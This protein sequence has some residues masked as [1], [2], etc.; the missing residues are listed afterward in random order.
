LKKWSLGLALALLAPGAV[1]Q[2][3][4]P[5]GG[6]ALELVAD[7]L[8][9]PVHL[10]A[11]PN[12][13]RLFIVEQTG[14]ILIV[15]D[16]Q[17]RATPFLDIRSK[18]RS[19]GERG[20]LSVAFHPN[21]A[22][23]GFF[24]VNYTDTQGNTQIERYRVGSDPDVAD[25]DSAKRILSIAQPQGNHNGGLS[26]FGPDGMLWIGTGDGGG[27]ND[28]QGNG[29]RRTT[30]LGK[31][32]RIDVDGG[33]PYAIPADNP[34]VN[35][36]DILPEIWALGLRNPW[37]F[38]FDRATGLL[39]IAD[40]GQNRIEEMNA[41]P[42]ARGG[43]NFGWNIMEG[44]EC[45]RTPDCQQTG[46]TLPVAE[47]DHSQ[48]CSVTGGY[49]YRGSRIPSAVGHYFFSDYCEGWV[50]SFRYDGE[51][52]TERR[53]WSLENVGRVLSFGED[54]GGELY[55]LV[56]RGRVYRMVPAN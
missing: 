49:V 48:G 56:D 12:D 29:Q 13:P 32:V 23:N 14:R 1:A 28:P 30:L 18:T 11:P 7:N 27:A 3:Y 19:G 46:L 40:V 50:R 20:L 55:L 36:D 44:S 35:Q 34:F 5:T 45:F 39:Y 21:Y 42:F 26:L 17:L 43:Y 15:R 24:F 47:Y 8:A 25:P 4:A 16:G 52:V 41:V 9:S 53:Q 22:A 10:T 31:M 2:E 51:R 37:R 33:D 38:A 54:A 6:V